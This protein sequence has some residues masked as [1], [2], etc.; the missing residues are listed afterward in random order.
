MS[1]NHH[2]VS[3]AGSS[4]HR[5][6]MRLLVPALSGGTA[7]ARLKLLQQ[8][9]NWVERPHSSHRTLFLW[10]GRCGGVTADP[11]EEPLKRRVHSRGMKIR[12]TH[13]PVSSRRAAGR[14]KQSI[15]LLTMKAS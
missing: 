6:D 11:L 8:G 10:T 13:L 2:V 7:R 1:A 5:D 4:P 3:A 15:S 9:L 12:P 14:K